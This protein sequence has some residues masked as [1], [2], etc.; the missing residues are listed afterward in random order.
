VRCANRNAITHAARTHFP[1]ANW[2][3]K[4]NS[5]N[6]VDMYRPLQPQAHSVTIRPDMASVNA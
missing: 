5:R 2:L 4:G 3:R 1:N 6:V